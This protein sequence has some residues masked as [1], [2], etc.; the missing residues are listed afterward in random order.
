MNLPVC[1]RHTTWLSASRKSVA[2]LAVLLG[3]VAAAFAQAPLSS[4][5]QSTRQTPP[6]VLNG[7]AK[8]V[9]HYNPNQKLRLAFA[10][11]PQH[12][13]E[14]RQLAAEL[15]DKKSAQFHK[16]LTAEQWKARFAPTAQDEQ[17]VVDWAKSQGLTITHR[18]PN[19]LLVDVEG[20]AGTIEKALSITINNYAINGKPFFSN[21]REPMLPANLASTVWAVQGLNNLEQERP[22][23]KRFQ[24]PQ[25]PEYVPGPAVAMGPVQHAD[26]DT[27]KLPAG[28][29]KAK[30]LK[31]SANPANIGSQMTGGAYDPTDIYSSE[32]YDFNALYAQGHCCNPLGNPGQTPPETSIAIA[33]FDST[34]LSDIAGFHTQYP[35]LAYNVQLYNIDGTPSPVGE[36]TMD[37]EW[38]TAMSNSFGSYQD[39]AK[40]YAYQGAN[41]NNVTITDVYNHMLSDGYARVFS[42][43]WAC[44]E[45]M[46]VPGAGDCYAATMDARDSI[47]LS[48][49]I[50]GWTLV[51]ASGDEGASATW[52]GAADGVFYPASDPNVVAA[53]GTT[54]SLSPGPS[55]NSEVA[56]SGG[57]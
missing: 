4:A 27:S 51:A 47:L 12:L 33:T 38:S 35:Y 13:D 17:A 7:T 29:R 8:L 42:T 31:G 25:R 37:I 45:Q 41:Y 36:G 19:R 49:V 57:P 32:A 53:G 11:K 20:T 54:L 9:E 26:A 5:G 18:Y 1:E 10:L 52:C 30:G 15:H 2:A 44:A 46:T 21:D 3:S 24:V 40:V 6:S 43:S 48:M 56:W 23:G 55:F 39:T 22:V 50:Q 34:D 16:F 14:E 28:L